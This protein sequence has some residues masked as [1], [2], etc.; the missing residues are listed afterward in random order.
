MTLESVKSFGNRNSWL[1]F[2]SVVAVETG[3]LFTLT[4]D[5]SPDVTLVCV[6]W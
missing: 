1:L 2:F 6:S 4:A 5:G 3:R